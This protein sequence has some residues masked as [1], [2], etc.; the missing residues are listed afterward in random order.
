MSTPSLSVFDVLMSSAHAAAK[1]KH[2]PPSSSPSPCPLPPQ[3]PFIFFHADG[4]GS[5]AE[6]ETTEFRLFAGRKESG[7]ESQG[8]K[9]SRIMTLLVDSTDC[10]PRYIICLL[11]EKLRLGYDEQ[12]L[13]AALSQAALYTEEHS[14]PPPEIHSP[15][16]EVI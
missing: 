2:L 8:K 9:M 15:L 5:T 3:K 4:Q 16:Q 7:K 12:T 14:K 1:K 13:L 6:E 11:Q 10:E